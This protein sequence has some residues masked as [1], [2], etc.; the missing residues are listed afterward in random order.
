MNKRIAVL[1]PISPQIADLQRTYPNIDLVCITNAS[2]NLQNQ[3]QG[4]D[5]VVGMTDFMRHRTDN[6]AIRSMGK[7]Y[8]RT[9]GSVSSVKRVINNWLEE[10]KNESSNIVSVGSGCSP[11]GSLDSRGLRKYARG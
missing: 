10:C 4:C 1:G 8:R 3:I 2:R 11:V 5:L 7:L 9:P 6:I